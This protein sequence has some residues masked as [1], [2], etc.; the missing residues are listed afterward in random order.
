MKTEDY[1]RLTDRKQIRRQLQT[2]KPYHN[3]IKEN[4]KKGYNFV[5]IFW[6]IIL[7]GIILWVFYTWGDDWGLLPK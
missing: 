1:E 7:A 2:D 3:P 4:L 6:L 5:K